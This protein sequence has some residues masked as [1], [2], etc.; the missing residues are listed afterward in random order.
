MEIMSDS[1]D[2]DECTDFTPEY[3]LKYNYKQTT[4]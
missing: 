4:V 2:D 1:D 3:D